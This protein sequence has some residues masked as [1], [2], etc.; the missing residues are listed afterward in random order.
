MNSRRAS[1]KFEEVAGN[2]LGLDFDSTESSS[3][4]AVGC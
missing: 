1:S 4:K 3:R 2:L